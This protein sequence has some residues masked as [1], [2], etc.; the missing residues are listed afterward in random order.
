MKVLGIIEIGD[1]L[2]GAERY[3]EVLAQGFKDSSLAFSVAVVGTS[4]A[5][6]LFADKL[7]VGGTQVIHLSRSPLDLLRAV[8]RMQPDIL[9]WNFQ[10][11]FAFN[12]GL[13]LWLPLGVPSVVVDHLPMRSA[14]PRW[15]ATRSVSN[16]RISRLIVSSEDSRA[17][18]QKHW[19]KAPPLAVVPNATTNTQRRIRSAPRPG[20]P[21]SL[22]M[23]CRLERQKD[24]LFA[25]DVVSALVADGEDVRLRIFGEGSLRFALDTRVRELSLGRRVTFGGHEPVPI[26]RML[27]ADLFL[28]CALEE[29]L[30]F[31]TLE[32][33]STGLP[34]VASDIGPHREIASRNEAVRLAPVRDRSGWLTAIRH[35]ATNLRVLSERS[36]G[37]ADAYPLQSMVAGHEAVYRDALPRGRRR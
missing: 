2:G 14:G 28:T 17:A 1:G 19:R 24:P 35:A 7:K 20:D 16:R 26:D 15:E 9:H 23:L 32:A 22:L 12:A 30:P 4:S 37:Q 36:V 21:L 11:P 8:R 18:A 5:A 31:A 10:S 33:L 29:G 6:A 25:L 27:D 13:W 3:F 34:V